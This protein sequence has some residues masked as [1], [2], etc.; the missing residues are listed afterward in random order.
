MDKPEP[1]SGTQISPSEPTRLQHAPARSARKPRPPF[2]RLLLP[3]AALTV[4]V[5][6]FQQMAQPDFAAV[7]RDPVIRLLTLAVVLGAAGLVAAYRFELV[8]ESTLTTIGLAFSVIVALA[9]AMVETAVPVSADRP[10]LGI[11][12]VAPWVLLVGVLVPDRPRWT[13]A[14]GLAAASM[15]PIAY[16]INTS[17]LGFTPAPWGRLI[18]WPAIN[19]AIAVLAWLIGQRLYGPPPHT[20]TAE[21][22][23]E[24]GK[25]RSARADRRRRH[26]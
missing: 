25:Y 3:I 17:R 22:A 26:G 15:W 24:I 10:V 5:I 6:A 4:I 1:F 21:T 8:F 19:Y 11:S 7:Y 9:I 16:A 12:A 13:L 18:V 2:A 20:D 23:D 14:A